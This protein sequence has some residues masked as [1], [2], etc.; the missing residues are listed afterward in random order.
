MNDPDDQPPLHKSVP[1]CYVSPIKEVF[2]TIHILIIYLYT[3]SSKGKF[4]KNCKKTFPILKYFHFFKSATIL[5]P[6]QKKF[7][8][9][10]VC[11]ILL[12]PQLI[13]KVF[14]YYIRIRRSTF[15]LEIFI[16]DTLYKYHVLSFNPFCPKS[17]DWT[18]ICP[19][20]FL[21]TLLIFLAEEW[22]ELGLVLF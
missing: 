19:F 17:S 12:L 13:S 3:H 6:G 18:F 22:L 16:K 20:Y 8:P 9:V 5:S 11:L 4:A 7:Y 10:H 1:L 15:I 14:R 2:Q 21:S